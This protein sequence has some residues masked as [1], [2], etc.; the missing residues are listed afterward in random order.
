MMEQEMKVQGIAE[1]N[2]EKMRIDKEKEVQRQK[3][4]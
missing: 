1:A 4:I 3:E 2:N